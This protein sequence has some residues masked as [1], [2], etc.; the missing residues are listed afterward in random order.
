MQCPKDEPLISSEPWSPDSTTKKYQATVE[1]ATATDDSLLSHSLPSQWEMPRRPSAEAHLSASLPPTPVQ[2]PPAKPSSSKVHF[3]RKR[4]VILH[5]KS[6]SINY[7]VKEEDE[8]VL[9]PVD[10][11]WGVLFDNGEL[12]TRMESVIRGLARHIVRHF[13]PVMA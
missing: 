10:A 2:S 4:P 1:D 13:S 6:S 11:S 5:N 9:S 7:P 3:S 12:T 8:P